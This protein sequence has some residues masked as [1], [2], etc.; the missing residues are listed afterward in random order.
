MYCHCL[1]HTYL[2]MWFKSITFTFEPH[3][4]ISVPTENAVM[5]DYDIMA[6]EQPTLLWLQTFY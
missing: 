6:Q 2:Y 5:W 4:Q 1:L 3:I